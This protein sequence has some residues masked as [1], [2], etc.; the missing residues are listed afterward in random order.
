M[1]MDCNEHVVHKLVTILNDAMTAD[2]IAMNKIIDARIETN[3]EMANHNTIQ[4]GLYDELNRLSPTG[5][6]YKVGLLGLVNGFSQSIGYKVYCDW[7][8]ERELNYGE[9]WYVK[10]IPEAMERIEE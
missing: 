6:T 2:P 8:T 5:Q 7:D 10:D 9:F 1:E 4:V 3:Q